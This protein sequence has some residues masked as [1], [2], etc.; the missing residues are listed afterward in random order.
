[1]HDEYQGSASPASSPAN[2]FLV[3]LLVVLTAALAYQNWTEDAD[4]DSPSLPADSALRRQVTPRGE[5]TSDEQQTID[6]FR[7]ASPSV[8][9]IRTK[10][11]Q[12]YVFGTVKEKELSSGT[13]VVWDREGHIV[14]NLHVLRDAL[15]TRDSELEVQFTDQSVGDVSIIG[16]VSEFDIAVLK[17]RADR[18]RLKPITLGTSEDLLVG[19]KVLAIGNPF[20][21][22]Q[23][24]STGVIGGLNRSVATEDQRGLLAGLI[25]TDA[26]IN[27]GNS[28]GP[29]LDSSGRMIGVN[30]A[31]FSPTGVYSGLGFAVPVSS[32]ISSVELLLAESN[33]N[34]RAI[35]GVRVISP[36]LAVELGMN[37]QLSRRG[38]FIRKIEPNGPAARAQ[39]E[40]ATQVGLRIIW[41]D[42]LH[43]IDGKPVRSVD[44]LQRVLD[45]YQPGDVVELQYYRAYELKSVQVT[46]DAPTLIR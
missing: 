28:G 39:L 18:D 17:V 19:Q 34:Q 12:S 4:P 45:D 21:F 26:A 25:Q 23:T 7:E 32:V 6:V 15:V 5:L 35:L 14:T 36:E 1:M 16:A 24:L 2:L 33:S 42:Q 38:L 37:P 10:G 20:G 41:G 44:D 31:I 11:V 40:P 8:V 22:N 27:P 3:V 46:L 9:F 13:G 43:A 30:T 29:L